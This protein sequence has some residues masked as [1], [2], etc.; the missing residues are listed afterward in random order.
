MLFVLGLALCLFHW[1]EA[2]W[3][4]EPKLMRYVAQA[5]PTGNAV[6]D[7]KAPK[8]YMELVKLMQVLSNYPGLHTLYEHPEVLFS[9]PRTNKR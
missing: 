2:G 1:T 3:R 9:I 4:N 5:T 6:D 8:N 7:Q